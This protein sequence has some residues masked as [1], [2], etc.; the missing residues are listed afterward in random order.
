[1]KPGPKIIRLYDTLDGRVPFSE[2]L[3]R[4]KDVTTAARIRARIDRA[5]DGNLGNYKALGTG[6]FELKFD[7][8]AGYRVYFAIDGDKIIILLSGGDK[9]SQRKD[10]EKAREFWTD[11]LMRK[12]K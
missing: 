12:R 6:L 9:S 1:M 3:L 5:E 7:F 10:I 2:W 8:G 4:L 11:Y